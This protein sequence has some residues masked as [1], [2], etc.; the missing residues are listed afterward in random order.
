MPIVSDWQ[1]PLE[2]SLDEV[3]KA[4][5]SAEELNRVRDT[6]AMLDPGTEGVDR[7][8]RHLEERFQQ[9]EAEYQRL[10][11]KIEQTGDKSEVE[12]AVA[13]LKA[14]GNYKEAAAMIAQ[15]EQKIKKIQFRKKKIGIIV[16]AALAALVAGIVILVQV[17]AANRQ[18]E[19]Q[20]TKT[21][22]REMMDAHQEA[23]ILPSLEKLIS[24]GVEISELVPLTETAAKNVALREGPEAAYAVLSTFGSASRPIVDYTPFNRWVLKQ[25]SE[26]S[27]P[28]GERWAFVKAYLKRGGGKDEDNGFASVYNE[29]LLSQAENEEARNAE[30]WKTWIEG[31]SPY[32]GLFTA[33]PE[34]ALKLSYRMRNDG[35]DL[36]S[37]FP[38]GILVSLP[39]ASSVSK[40]NEWY[41]TDDEY[42][43][44]PRT[45]K[46]LPISVA[47]NA[48]KEMYYSTSGSEG[49]LKNKVAEI[50]ETDAHYSVYL[51]P[52]YLMDISENFRA[53]TFDECT[54][55]LAVLKSY[56]LS[57]YTYTTTTYSGTQSPFFSIGQNTSTSTSNYRGY[58]TAVDAI[59]LYDSEDPGHFTVF[60]SSF[61]SPII[62][63]DGWYD[64]NKDRSNSDV[65]TE[66]NSL[67]VH[68]QAWLQASFDETLENLDVYML[69][70]LLSS[71]EQAAE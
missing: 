70:V 45:D 58:Y 19:I 3:L 11:H 25:T 50:Q 34:T 62:S 57:G 8:R 56:L 23:E 37:A 27:L 67:G 46:I 14:L 2:E 39:I 41:R 49:S 43:P 59:V 63:E 69:W 64:K 38:D 10:V 22:I 9:V 35:V 47:E 54:S 48:S 71:E 52:G 4:T 15:G 26:E 66:E 68:D 60:D 5:S 42:S 20:A 6:L 21:Q 32:T 7:V 33:D 1:K 29:Y 65:Y 51:L 18:K 55:Y 12:S 53:N 24:L 61:H 36:K 40:M 30:E 16:A 28:V 44:P 17:N 13:G 31:I